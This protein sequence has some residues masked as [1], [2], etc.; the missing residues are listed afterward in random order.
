LLANWHREIAVALALEMV[1]TRDQYVLD[2]WVRGEISEEEMR[3]GIRYNDDWGY[4]WSV[5]QSSAPGA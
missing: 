5:C 4:D 3:A 2:E 1:F